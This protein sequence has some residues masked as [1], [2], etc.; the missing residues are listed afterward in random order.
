MEPQRTTFEDSSSRIGS[1]K[2]VPN[3]MASQKFWLD[4]WQL[5]AAIPPH[6]IGPSRALIEAYRSVALKKMAE[7]SSKLAESKLEDD[8]DGN[9]AD[10]NGIFALAWAAHALL[11]SR[12]ETAS[13][14]AGSKTFSWLQ[15]IGCVIMLEACCCRFVT[16]NNLTQSPLFPIL[17]QDTLAALQATQ[18]QQQQQ[19]PQSHQQYQILRA[20]MELERE[21]LLEL[22]ESFIPDMIGRQHFS[23]GKAPPDL[24]QRMEDSVN[25]LTKQ[26]QRD[27]YL[28]PAV[29]AS[30]EPE[31]SDVKRLVESHR[32]MPTVSVHALLQPMPALV[33]PF[34]RPYPPTHLPFMGYYEDDE[35]LTER[36]QTEVLEYL[37]AELQWLTPT[38]LRLMLLPDDESEDKEANE[39]YK[40]VLELLKTQAF[41]KP[42]A[43]N[44]QHS[45]M[46]LLGS[47][48]VNSDDGS[49]EEDEEHRETSNRL[50][51][52]SG[53]TPQ[54]LPRLVEYNPL[55]A[56]ECVLRILSGDDED[57]K[58]DYLSSLVGMDMS[59]HSMEVVNRLATH[60]PPILHPEYIH[61]FIS[62]CIATCENVPDRHAQNRLVR[63]VCVFIQSL[64][65]NK[66]VQVNDIYFE[67][68]SFCV[69]FSRIREAS[70]L[71]KSM[72]EL[73]AG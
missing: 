15:K 2:V 32:D 1:K 6:T 20:E 26:F 44:D 64:L 57:E 49:A 10:A 61:L 62:S 16:E 13:L 50:V 14:L 60:Q 22:A 71:F 4:Y 48:K 52:E 69:E 56:N 40:Q 73:H 11:S 31:I 28:I 51:K 63:L 8:G 66:I 37:H 18:M 46:E 53:L 7:L 3:T 30:K 70:S 17:L 29:L 58:N 27:S 47:K 19:R 45:V 42:L 21:C 41:S 39:R 35:A 54:S 33:A 67:L 38:N 65:R 25:R 9:T 24:M 72:K 68:Q 55:V 34:A 5:L 23:Q 43:P 59:L 12:P 36:E